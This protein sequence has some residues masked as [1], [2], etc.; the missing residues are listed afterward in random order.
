MYVAP[1]D[2]WVS[3][4]VNGNTLTVIVSENTGDETRFA[5]VRLTPTATGVDG[6]P[7]VDGNY[8]YLDS[9]HKSG[10]NRPCL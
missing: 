10:L 3:T 9:L 4:S 7:D 6:N 1:E 5:Y 2:N 8:V